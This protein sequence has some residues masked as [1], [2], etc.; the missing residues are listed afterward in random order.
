MLLHFS[1][2]VALIKIHMHE[3]RYQEMLEP[4]R[5]RVKNEPAVQ[6]DSVAAT[7]SDCCCSIVI[8]L[9]KER[10]GNKVRTGL[11]TNVQIEFR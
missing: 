2:I 9:R 6:G 8:S 3:G 10:E 1:V 4:P 11:K 7:A 5:L